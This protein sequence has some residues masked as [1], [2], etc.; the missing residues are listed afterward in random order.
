MYELGYEKLSDTFLVKKVGEYTINIS[1]SDN[2]IDAITGYIDNVIVNLPDD[3][4]NNIKKDILQC[5]K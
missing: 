4:V 2:K 1:I 5:V 3:I